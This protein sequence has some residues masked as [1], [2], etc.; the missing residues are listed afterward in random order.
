MLR[1]KFRCHFCLGLCIHGALSI[2]SLEDNRAQILRHRSLCII[3]IIKACSGIY[4]FQSAGRLYPGVWTAYYFIYEFAHLLPNIWSWLFSLF[5][6]ASRADAVRAAKSELS[7]TVMAQDPDKQVGILAVTL[8][9]FVLA[10]VSVGLRCYVR[11]SM[12]HAFGADDALTVC[13]L[14]C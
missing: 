12:L 8:I 11:I 4:T 7:S 1:V 10:W 5:L 14:V 3:S 2:Y 9:F 13:S 6:I